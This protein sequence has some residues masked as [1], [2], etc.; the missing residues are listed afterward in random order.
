MKT[1]ILMIAVATTGLVTFGNTTPSFE[2]SNDA[3]PFGTSIQFSSGPLDK[4]VTFY[5]Q[6]K[7]ALTADN[8]KDAA[9][10]G[11][12]LKA[13]WTQLEK[14]TMND[15]QKK[16][17]KDN[18]ENAIKDATSI[19]KNGDNIK[20]QRDHFESLSNTILD[21]IKVFGSSQT[22]YKDYCPMKKAS[23]LS[24]VKNIKNPYYGKTMLTCGMIKETFDK[25]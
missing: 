14:A 25:Q 3:V 15:A 22:L 9:K 17:F 10:A 11:E 1:Y 2:I 19:A 4:V 21:M 5:L 20:I 12:Q 18:N 13:A 23:W 6:V 24:E 7:N 16:A 8:S